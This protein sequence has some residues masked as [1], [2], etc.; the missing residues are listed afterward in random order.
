MK[1]KEIE[2][3][4]KDRV[5]LQLQNEIMNLKKNKGEGKKLVKNKTNKN[6]SPQIPPT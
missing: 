1:N 2:A 6:N 5:I 3:Y 4:G